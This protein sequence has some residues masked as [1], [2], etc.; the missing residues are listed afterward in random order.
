MT[1]ADQRRYVRFKTPVTVELSG[2]GGFQTCLTDDLGAGGCR[3]TVVM[4]LQTGT[5]VRVRLRSDR[6]GQEASGT[7]TVAWSS[8]NPPYQVGL[9]FSTLLVEGMVPFLRAL[10]GPARLLT[11]GHG[12]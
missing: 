10:I 5:A 7:A 8:R 4:P 3:V 1:P 2:A 11:P 12:Q 6:G 9:A